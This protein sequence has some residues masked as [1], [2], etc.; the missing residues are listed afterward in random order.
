[1]IDSLIKGAFDLAGGF[2]GQQG[3]REAAERNAAMQKQ[4]NDENWAHSLHMAQNS[5][6]MRANDAAAAGIHPL[7]ALGASTMSFA[8]AQVGASSPN[9]NAPLADSLRSMGQDVSRAAGAA[10]SPAQKTV[11]AVGAQQQV[12]SNKLDLET[13][14]LNNTLLRAKIAKEVGT[15]PGAPVI[16]PTLEPGPV[17]QPQDKVKGTAPLTIS[18]NRWGVDRSTSPMKDFEDRYGDEG[19][20]A[21]M[22]PFM[23]LDRDLQHNYGPPES[24][25][26]QM[27]RW[28]YNTISRELVEEGKNA[29]QFGQ[30]IHDWYKRQ[31]WFY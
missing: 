13:K 28:G 30:K 7:Y 25:P 17:I 9:F 22:M 29:K 6:Q 2:L 19:P 21:S 5:I 20:V 4:I 15:P 16:G 31:R 3:A 23:V 8:P 26:G 18:G 12:A 10:L 11:A 27:A 14:S 24:W 1:M